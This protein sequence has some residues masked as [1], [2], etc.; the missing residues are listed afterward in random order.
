MPFAP[1]SLKADTH[2]S[3]ELRAGAGLR[4]S[5]TRYAPRA[6]LGRHHH[7]EASLSLVIAGSCEERIGT[8]RF[9]CRQAQVVYKRGDVEHEDHFGGDGFHGV[10][11][12]VVPG[13]HH[14]LRELL[15]RL[16]DA[17]VIG[18]PRARTLVRR[19]ATESRERLPGHELVVESCALELWATIARV[20]NGGERHRSLSVRRAQE[21][22]DAHLAQPVSLASAAQAAGV[23]PVHLAQ[24]FRRSFGRSVG[25]YVRERRI[26]LACRLLSTTSTPIGQIALDAGFADHSHLSRAL[27]AHTGLTPSQYR[28]E[29][30]R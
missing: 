23:H 8:R 2:A 19:L 9:E 27:R 30:E 26:E 1:H 17:L 6:R 13:A 16:P 22:L 4:A 18:T 29:H 20:E 15:G 24:A 5:V 10:F 14:A 11:I 28:R 3:L 12:E 7:A 21:Y 25:E